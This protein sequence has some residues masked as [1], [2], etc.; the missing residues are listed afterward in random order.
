MKTAD[1]LQVGEWF[2]GTCWQEDFKAGQFE[3]R[4][5]GNRRRVIDGR[6]VTVAVTF[7]GDALTAKKLLNMFATLPVG[8]T[9]QVGSPDA[10]WVAGTRDMRSPRVSLIDWYILSERQ[11]EKAA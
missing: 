6:N 4:A 8:D 11:W 3:N 5:D 2:I 7:E 10:L 9:L 1:Q